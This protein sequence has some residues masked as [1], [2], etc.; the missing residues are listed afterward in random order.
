[1]RRLFADCEEFMARRGWEL[2]ECYID[3]AGA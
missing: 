3:P 1:M 2:A